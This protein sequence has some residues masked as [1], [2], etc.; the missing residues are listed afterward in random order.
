MNKFTVSLYKLLA[1]VGLIAVVSAFPNLAFSASPPPKLVL[2]FNLVEYYL[3][4]R[5]GTIKVYSVSGP[6]YGTP[7]G[8][9][10]PSLKSLDT[11]L[12]VV[13]T[14][15]S[16]GGCFGSFLAGGQQ[17]GWLL[18]PVTDKATIQSFYPSASLI[19]AAYGVITG[20]FGDIGY[21]VGNNCDGSTY[22]EKWAYW[23]IFLRT[24]SSYY[25]NYGYLVGDGWY[26]TERYPQGNWY[27]IYSDKPL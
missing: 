1:I 9:L 6:E 19:S 10:D 11:G 20:E 22:K 21:A 26:Q 18:G 15:E 12:G 23:L 16:K 4:G 25:P 13:T 5:T 3:N 27:Y 14:W 8:K 2:S 7:I 24:T 17:V